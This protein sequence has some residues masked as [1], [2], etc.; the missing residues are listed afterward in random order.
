MWIGLSKIKPGSSPGPLPPGANLEALKAYRDVA[1]KVIEA[2]KDGV[3]TQAVRV[4]AIDKV[5]GK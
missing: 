4:Q 3:G 1:V 5:F 2:G